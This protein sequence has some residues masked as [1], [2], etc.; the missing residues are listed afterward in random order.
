MARFF[1]RPSVCERGPETPPIEYDQPTESTAV[2]KN[3]IQP[4]PVWYAYNSLTHT[5]LP[6]DVPTVVDQAFGLPI[7]N[8][9]AH[10]LNTLVTA[11][12]QLS[13]VND[14]VTGPDSKLVAT[15]DMYLYKRRAR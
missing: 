14:L 7:I 9:A 5:P 13:R 6:A 3:G 11:L 15:M 1:K 8:A 2:R 12:E 10:K 4:V